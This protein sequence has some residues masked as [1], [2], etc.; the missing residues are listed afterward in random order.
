MDWIASDKT[1]VQ[2]SKTTLAAY[3][4]ERFLGIIIHGGSVVHKNVPLLFFE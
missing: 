2:L 4:V 1:A 3:N